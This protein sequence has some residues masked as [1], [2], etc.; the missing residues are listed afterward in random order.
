MNPLRI[1]AFT[2]ASPL[3]HGLAAQRDALRAGRTGLAQGAFEDSA[4][5]CWVGAVA[6][7]ETALGGEWAPWDCRNHRLAAL[8][9]DQD[10]FRAAVAGAVARHGAERIAVFVGT[11]TSGTLTSE[12]ACR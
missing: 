3:G 7:L 4:L 12:H 8:A 10:D 5:S 1:S 11:S 2:L 9:L 6:G